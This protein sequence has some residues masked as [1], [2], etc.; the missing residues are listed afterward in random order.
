MGLKYA[1]APADWTD[2]ATL[3]FN[4][5]PVVESDAIASFILE[6]SDQTIAAKALQETA[7]L[8]DNLRI[9]KNLQSKIKNLE[10]ENRDLE[11]FASAVSHDLQSPLR[12]I[13]GFL[14]LLQ[15]KHGGD[16]DLEGQKYVSYTIDGAARMQQLITDMLSYSR[17]VSRELEYYET[18]M[19]EILSDV[20]ADLQADLAASGGEIFVNMLPTL[21]VDPSQIRQVFYNLVCNAL[22]FRKKDVTPVVNISAKRVSGKWVFAVADNGIGFDPALTSHLFQPFR[23]LVSKEKYPGTG[24]GLAITRKIIERHG[25]QIWAEAVPGE[26][27][28]FL[29]SLPSH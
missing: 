17:A 28:T 15:N 20:C 10:R 25:G 12:T 24:I 29:F 9:E 11:F 21:A 13:R 8:T 22:K 19:M 14:T 18:D 5:T 16:L 23:R 27:A 1:R 3:S 7:F 2:E 6:D 26:G 4:N